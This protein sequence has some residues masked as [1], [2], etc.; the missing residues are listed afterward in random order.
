MKPINLFLRL[1]ALQQQPPKLFATVK[2]LA[3]NQAQIEY[4]GGVRTMVSN[5]ISATVD[6]AVFVR[7][8]EIVERA[9]DLPYV[10]AQI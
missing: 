10:M 8:G 6:Q 3:G 9:P 4:P 1:Q 2:V 5:P 7:A